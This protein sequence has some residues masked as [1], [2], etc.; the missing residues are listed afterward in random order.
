MASRFVPDRFLIKV[1]AL[2][3]CL[4]ENKRYYASRLREGT[5]APDHPAHGW[6][7]TYYGHRT[8]NYGW[9]WVGVA[10]Q[11]T[12]AASDPAGVQSRLKLVIS[13]AHPCLIF[14][15]FSHTTGVLA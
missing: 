9:I 5:A 2:V 12:A 13:G 4:I 6:Y 15:S 7:M 8:I 11:G 10:R 3:I 14:S 1:R